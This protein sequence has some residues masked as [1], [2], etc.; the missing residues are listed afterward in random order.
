MLVTKV[1]V[2]G[3]GLRG[4]V[5][6]ALDWLVDVVRVR[7]DRE[8]SDRKAGGRRGT[9]MELHLDQ[10]VHVDVELAKHG[11]VV[12]VP[13]LGVL[14]ELGESDIKE[15]RTGIVFEGWVFAGG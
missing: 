14:A 3:V 13:V 4:V 1:L 9:D 12:P 15:V 10:L 8:S 11:A 6:A 7:E 2:G 5:G